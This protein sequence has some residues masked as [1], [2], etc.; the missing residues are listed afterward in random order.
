MFP[1]DVP[2][3]MRPLIHA[4]KP[5]SAARNASNHTPPTPAQGGPA[6]WPPASA[7]PPPP[8]VIPCAC[9][10]SGIANR[11][12]ALAVTLVF[13]LIDM[14]HLLGQWSCFAPLWQRNHHHLTLVPLNPSQFCDPTCKCKRAPLS[15]VC[16]D[17]SNT[18]ETSLCHVKEGRL[19]S[20]SHPSILKEVQLRLPRGCSGRSA[21]AQ[22]RRV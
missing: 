8:L 19:A 13:Q 22:L 6:A 5:S 15:Q 2:T 14:C 4:E 16:G 3:K 21:L 12:A 7:P 11:L 17:G 10:E 20:I 18:P 1:C 9:A